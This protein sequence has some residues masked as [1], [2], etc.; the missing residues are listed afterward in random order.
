MHTARPVQT[1]NPYRRGPHPTSLTLG[2]LPPTAGEGSALRQRGKSQT[3]TH[4]RPPRRGGACPSRVVRTRTTAAPRRMRR[5]TKGTA[6]HRSPPY[7]TMAKS[8]IPVRF[9]EEEGGSGYG[10]GA[11]KRSCGMERASSDDVG[12]PPVGRRA[13]RTDATAAPRRIRTVSRLRKP[14]PAAGECKDPKSLIWSV[15]P[16]FS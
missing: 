3:P 1:I 14:S 2:H 5:K 13:V 15:V 12:R 10:A 6:G 8:N 16:C 11:R 4:C 9:G 7:G